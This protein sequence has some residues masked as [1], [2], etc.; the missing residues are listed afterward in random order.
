MAGPST[1]QA[2]KAV[3]GPVPTGSSTREGRCA[4]ATRGTLLAV[5]IA[6]G[7]LLAGS[8]RAQT[9]REEVRFPVPTGGTGPALSGMMLLGYLR[10]PE[11]RSPAAAIVL[12]HGCG[13][14]ADGLDRNW[15]VRLQSWG[16]AVLTVDSLTPR[17]M[18]N[19]CRGGAPAGR[20]LDAYGALRLLTSLPFVDP[21]R[22]AIMGLSEGGA[23]AL[24]DVEH[25]GIEGAFRHKFKAAVAFYPGCAES[26]R[27][28][29]PT[30]VLNGALDDWSSA[31]ACRKMVAQEDDL[32]VTRRK[33]ASAPVSLVILPSAYHKFDDPRFVPGHRYLG[34]ELKY[35]EA[36]LTQAAE[37][38]RSFFK[39]ELDSR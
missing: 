7:V 12:L 17:G 13:G 34:H 10:Q 25:A 19:S 22:V 35:D 30:L 21:S 26:G 38:V 28:T 5:W 18:N 24:M 27:V 11:Q 33:G 3:D 23:M 29:V 20:L 15:G 39:A 6:A 37:H 36:A 14:D 9:A 31:D 32:G 2:R 16:Y 8:A 1:R 4:V